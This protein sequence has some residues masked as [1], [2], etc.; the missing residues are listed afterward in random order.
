MQIQFKKLSEKAK[1]PTYSK[2]GD[3]GLDLTA[4]DKRFTKHPG[5]GEV[6]FIE[7]DTGLAF[8]IPKGHVGLLFPRSSISKTSLTLANAV[9]VVDSNYR[10]EVKLRFRVKDYRFSELPSYEIGE[11]IGQLIIMPIPK[12][13]LQ[14]VE[15]LDETNRGTGAFGSSGR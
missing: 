8:S 4:T 10:G 12:V 14:E 7:Y 5:S 6:M 15:E 2:V 9:G 1:T 11:R 3:A 13:E